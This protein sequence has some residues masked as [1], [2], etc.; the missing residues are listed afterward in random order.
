ARS[1]RTGR[2]HPGTVHRTLSPAMDIQ[3]ASNFERLLYEIRDR[4]PDAVQRDMAG[5]ARGQ[6]ICVTARERAETGKRFKGSMVT[7]DQTI[8]TMRDIRDLCGVQIDPHT[9]VGIAAARLAGALD[10]NYRATAAPVIALAT[11][12]PAKF[13]DAVRQ[14]L[15]EEPE[16]PEPLA[17]CMEAPERV[18]TLPADY[19]RLAD[20]LRRAA[21]AVPA[22]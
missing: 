1:R 21:A 3:V 2:Y 17:R 12:H 10:R 18:T 11:A 7:E 5:L 14:A 16:T 9:A 19:T 13:P 22:P 8:H 20:H 6:A 15:S 4:E